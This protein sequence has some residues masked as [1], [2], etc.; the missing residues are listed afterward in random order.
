MQRPLIV[1][2]GLATGLEELGHELHPRLWSAGVF[3]EAP[4]FV[5]E[6]HAAYLA[7]GAEIL[8]T[9]SYQMSFEGLAREGL[10]SAAAE[11]AR[12]LR[13]RAR[14]TEKASVAT[15]NRTL[16]FGIVGDPRGTNRS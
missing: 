10:D 1:D 7:A 14:H 2:G 8:A 12:C 16:L 9:A 6:L 13:V 11:T 15:T 3:L 4:Q 5:E